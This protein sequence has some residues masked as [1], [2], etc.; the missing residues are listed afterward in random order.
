MT[1]G[2]QGWRPVQTYSLE[3]TPPFHTIVDIWWLDAE[4][5]AVD[6][7]VVRTLLE[8]FSCY[9]DVLLLTTRYVSHVPSLINV[10]AHSWNAFTEKASVQNTLI[11]APLGLVAS[12]NL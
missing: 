12:R 4:A 11:E 7:R 9:L 8:C 6:Q 3:D 5:H 2:S 1:T 10:R